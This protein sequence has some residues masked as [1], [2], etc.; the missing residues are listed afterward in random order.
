MCLIETLEL[1]FIDE[2]LQANCIANS[3]QKYH[4]DAKNNKGGQ[5]LENRL[6]KHLEQLVVP[7]DQNLQTRLIAKAHCQVSTTH[8]SKNKTQKIIGNYYYQPRIIV[9]IN[10]YIQNYNNYYQ[11]TIPQDKTPRL[12]KPLLI[13]ERP[14]KHISIDFHKLPKDYNRYNVVILLVDYFGKRPILIPCYKTIIAKKVV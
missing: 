11:S 4:E 13:L 1:D 3:L 2:L 9:D 10:Q 5:T 14:W 12:L 7:R 8:P 6:L